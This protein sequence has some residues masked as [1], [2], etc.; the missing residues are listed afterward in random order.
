M[1][2]KKLTAVFGRLEN[3]TLTL[4]DGLNVITAPN[5]SGK[6]T[7][8]AFLCAMLYGI[9]TSERKSK[10]NL[11]VKEKYRPWSGAAMAGTMELEWNGR[12]ITLERGTSGRT[13]MGAFSA[14]ATESGL[15]IPE[16]TAEDCGSLLIGAERSVFER[17]ALIRQAALA[18]TPDSALEQRLHALVTTGEEG[19]G[20]TQVEKSLRDLKN[21]IWFRKS[22][23]LPQCEAELA[24]LDDRLA[25]IR[26]ANRNDLA[27]TER[28]RTLE[29]EHTAARAQLTAV[30]AREQAEK[31]RQLRSAEQEA[32]QTAVEAARMQAEVASLPERDTLSAL[33]SEL[34]GLLALP[35]VPSAGARP[36][37][38]VPPAYFSGLSGDR[39]VELAA[40]TCAKY[41]ELRALAAAPRRAALLLAIV[42]AVLAASGGG[43]LLLSPPLGGA[44]LGAGVLLGAFALLRRRSDK[45]RRAEADAQAQ[46][47]LREADAASPDALRRAA[48]DHRDALLRYDQQ[49]A[50]YEQ[51]VAQQQAL[52]REQQ[53]RREAFLQKTAAFAPAATLSASRAALSDALARR[54]LA[55]SASVRADAAQA[56]CEAVRRAVGALPTDMD[57]PDDG[58]PLPA[59]PA[60]EHRL[61]QL[62]A[63][64][65]AVRSQLDRGRGSISAL[66]DPA[67]LE[68]RR[69]AAQ[70]RREALLAQHDALTLAL[71][72]LGRANDELQT[73]FAPQ[74]GREAARIMSRLTGG[75]YEAVQLDRD[76]SIAAR[77]ADDVLSRP[78]AAL[79]GG[80]ADQLYL[81]VRLAIAS[82]A[83]PDDAPLL[84]DDA[85]VQFDDARLAAAMALLRDMAQT[86]QVILFTCQSREQAWLDAQH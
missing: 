44:L 21:H 24:E 58:A 65:A 79:S 48:T 52:A 30:T 59:R 11:P 57:I 38:P 20:Y 53:T 5:E 75:R 32:A 54:E 51:A 60:L 80:T 84:L 82:V 9:D 40:Q 7:W 63:E 29:Q 10:T 31:L 49:C 71:D 8:S 3:E 67:E 19:P 86:R 28:L 61:A 70:T 17:S 64:L 47:L 76:L 39:A 14:R 37:E 55:Q 78:L 66:G 27:L 1:K 85:L 4:H 34:S 22:G 45:K 18:I 62:E 23:L 81:A 12:A 50:A 73:R 6:S 41:D 74:I 69:E 16:L 25:A 2:I 68:A 77:A 72:A 46:A 13:P 36:E 26:A 35:P 33:L 43:L 42:A 56:R 15:P 83:L